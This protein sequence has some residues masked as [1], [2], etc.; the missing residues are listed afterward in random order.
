MSKANGVGIASV[1]RDVAVGIA[2]VVRGRCEVPVTSARERV[3]REVGIF[4]VPAVIR[5]D[6]PPLRI[7]MLTPTSL[8][9][10]LIDE[11]PSPY[12]GDP[13]PSR[14]PAVNLLQE[15][16]KCAGTLGFRSQWTQPPAACSPL[17]QGGSRD[18][19][20]HGPFLAHGTARHR[21]RA[22]PASRRGRRPGRVI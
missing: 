2:L 21:G 4:G 14:Q 11:K 1:R 3:E 7:A 6:L 20:R 13:A 18:R 5:E 8:P 9:I 17:P 22:G 10:L 16:R 15:C 12:P 19:W